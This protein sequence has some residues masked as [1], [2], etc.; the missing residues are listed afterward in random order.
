MVALVRGK[1][2][3]CFSEDG[4]GKLLKNQYFF[5]PNSSCTMYIVPQAGRQAKEWRKSVYSSVSV[6]SNDKSISIIEVY[7]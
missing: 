2:N 6:Q 4:P 3:Y 1:K 7:R 5:T